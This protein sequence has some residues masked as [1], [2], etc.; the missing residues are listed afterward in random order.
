MDRIE[1][2]FRQD[3]IWEYSCKKEKLGSFQYLIL[4]N[5]MLYCV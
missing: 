2:G 1:A 5:L 3:T 4:E